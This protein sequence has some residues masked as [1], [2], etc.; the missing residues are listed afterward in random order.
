[1]AIRYGKRELEKT[2]DFRFTYNEFL[3]DVTITFPVPVGRFKNHLKVIAH[4]GK[5]IEL[6]KPGLGGSF[7]LSYSYCG[8]FETRKA[9]FKPLHKWAIAKYG[10]LPTTERDKAYAAL[11]ASA[12]LI[13]RN[14]LKREDK[15]H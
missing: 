10:K 6:A 7:N 13:A 8:H 1:M 2:F 4:N 9:T 5:G 15:I 3:S 12:V 11:V 14:I